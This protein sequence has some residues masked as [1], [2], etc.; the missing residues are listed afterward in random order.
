MALCSHVVEA[1]GVRSSERRRAWADSSKRASV[2]DAELRPRVVDALLTTG[3]CPADPR[4]LRWAVAV[5]PEEPGLTP[6]LTSSATSPSST[7]SPRR[8]ARRRLA[9]RRHARRRH[10]RRRLRLACAAPPAPRCLC[11]DACAATPAPRRLTPRCRAR[12]CLAR[13]RLRRQTG[14]GQPARQLSREQSV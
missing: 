3:S 4:R 11:R 6:A 7:R 9:R 12:R 8:L 14:R 10:A 1:A 5:W 2:P 13:L